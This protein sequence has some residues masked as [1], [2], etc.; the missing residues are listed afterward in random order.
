MKQMDQ[1]YSFKSSVKPIEFTVNVF[2]I[3]NKVEDNTVHLYRLFTDISLGLLDTIEIPFSKLTLDEYGST[4]CKLLKDVISLTG[5]DKSRYVTKELFLKW[6]RNQI[7]SI[8]N[9]PVS[10][11]DER[12]SIMFKLYKDDKRVSYNFQLDLI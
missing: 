7:T 9:T 12:N 10:Y 4:Y 6:F 8:P 1:V 2:T 3:S 5:V 11:M